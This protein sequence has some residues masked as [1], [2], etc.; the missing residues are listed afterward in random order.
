MS[1]IRI[2]K[3]DFENFSIEDKKE[4][5][6]QLFR[7]SPSLKSR[8]SVVYFPPGITRDWSSHETEQIVFA[9][10]GEGI[11]SM[12]PDPIYLKKGVAVLIPKDKVH[13][14]G[15]IKDNY[16]LQLSIIF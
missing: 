2:E 16:F 12:E 3:V 6:I 11:L 14:H 5:I 4:T 10:D 1:D 8:V 7:K 9:I 13:R 15:A